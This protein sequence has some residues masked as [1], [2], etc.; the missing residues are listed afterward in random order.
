MKPD[1]DNGSLPAAYVSA[2]IRRAGAALLVSHLASL[3]RA[4]ALPL[5]SIVWNDGQG[6]HDRREWHSF[7]VVSAGAGATLRVSDDDLLAL[8]NDERIA[9]SPVGVLVRECL[10]ELVRTAPADATA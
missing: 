4:R 7:H 1:L 9:E 3:L 6:A 5:G 10:D 2:E 8:M